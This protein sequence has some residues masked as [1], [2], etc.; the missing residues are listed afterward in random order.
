MCDF[1]L[2]MNIEM[3]T[4][5]ASF[6]GVWVGSKCTLFVAIQTLEGVSLGFDIFC[7][8]VNMSSTS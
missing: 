4:E 3:L 8:N 5:F 1:L 7:V 2:R 6:G